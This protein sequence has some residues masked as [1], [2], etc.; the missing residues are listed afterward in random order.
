MKKNDKVF[1][2]LGSSNHTEAERA[3]NDFY[4]TD[5]SAVEKLLELEQ[6]SR[7]IWEPA[8]GQGHISRVLE[9]HGHEVFST[10][11]VNRGYGN[12][13]SVDFLAQNIPDFD[14][15]IITNPP[16]SHAL[17]FVKRSLEIVRPGGKVAMFLKLQ[18]LEGLERGEFY[19]ATPPKK[20]YVS[21]GRLACAKNGDFAHTNNAIAFAWYI[22]ERGYTGKPVLDWFN[23]KSAKKAA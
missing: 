13:E 21:S 10:D 4:A 14:G 1:T 15:D 18:F 22:W 5:P 19:E 17:E 9:S 7:R 6:F 23:G 8:C 16:Y 3:A 11:L 2:P 20:V 12:P